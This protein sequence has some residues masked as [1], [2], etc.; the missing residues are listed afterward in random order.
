MHRFHQNKEI[1][2]G[3]LCSENANPSNL[4]GTLR[5]S[6]KDH[7]LNHAR[8][9]L[10]K[11]ELHV[12]SFHKCIDELI[13]TRTSS[14]TQSIVY[15]RKVSPKYSNP[16][17]ARNGRNEESE[18]T[19]SWRSLSAKKRK[20]RDNSTAHFHCSKCKNTW[21][22]WLILGIFNDDS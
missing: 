14:T 7:L 17:C 2:S 21:I 12:E 4:R 5:E 9:D 18:R 6:N 10:A 3:F 8:S 20:S 1:W 15:Q 16:K 19:A 11:Q 13:S 22:L